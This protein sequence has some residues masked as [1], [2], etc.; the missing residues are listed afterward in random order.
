MN[1]VNLMQLWLRRNLPVACYLFSWTVSVVGLIFCSLLATSKAC[2]AEIPLAAEI[3]RVSDK[4]EGARVRIEGERQIPPPTATAGM[5]LKQFSDKLEIPSDN[6]SW[7]KL[8]FLGKPS[9]ETLLQAGTDTTPSVYSFPCH[10]KGTLTIGWSK[11]SR[12]ACANGLIVYSKG[13]PIA[14]N[15]PIT[16][17][18][19]SNLG[20]SSLVSDSGPWQIAQ[21]SNQRAWYC[22]TIAGD[23][24][25]VAA[26]PLSL[27]EACR[28]AL[29]KCNLGNPDGNCAIASEGEWNIDEPK[30]LVSSRCAG[31][32][33]RSRPG[34]GMN[35]LEEVLPLMEKDTHFYKEKA[36]IVDVFSADSFMVSLKE[37]ADLGKASAEPTLIQTHQVQ[38]DLAVDVLVGSIDIISESRPNGLHLEKGFG[39][40]L[41]QN[42]LKEVECKKTYNSPPM[43]EFF[44]LESWKNPNDEAFTQ[45]VGSRLKEYQDAFCQGGGKNENNPPAPSPRGPRIIINFPFPSSPSVPNNRNNQGD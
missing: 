26:S 14:Q 2:V 29:A 4:G 38:D 19:L 23:A 32:S 25:E 27:D 1:R 9:M 17:V 41:K 22:S 8:Y 37:S 40:S 12:G 11:E 20:Q 16:L 45:A 43:K 44:N 13:Q 35:M 3:V 21:S 42:S 18:S 34:T 5:R 15:R 36:C 24:W 10:L 31:N 28:N 39:Y 30:L 6:L 33:F 7:A